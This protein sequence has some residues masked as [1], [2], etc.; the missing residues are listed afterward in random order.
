VRVVTLT[1]EQAVLEL[2]RNP[3]YADLVRDAYLGPDVEG[4]A[5]RFLASEEF[6][7]VLRL[8]GDRARGGS[9]LDVG[10]GTGVAS[11]AFARSG[12]R[13]VVAL[14]PDSGDVVGQG[15]I[16]RISNGLPITI[17]TG[18]G[19]ALPFPDARFDVVYARQV[20]HHASDLDAL[21]RECARVVVPG[22][23]VLATREHVVDDEAQLRAFLASHPVHQ[24]AG[25]ENAHSLEAYR[26]AFRRA[27]LVR[28]RVLG[29]YDSVINAFPAFQDE[30]SLAE[31]PRRVL[32][33]WFGTV[34]RLVARVPGVQGV[35]RRW[36]DE[37][38]PGRLYSFVG[39]K[40]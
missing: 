14:E 19:E 35:V 3:R 20:L 18:V 9:V 32:E 31:Y 6:A 33:G 37:P 22:G 26:A 17:A 30:R 34:G 38:V 28:L 10:A 27:G 13:E 40:L 21:V 12:A 25:G 11:Y 1:T 23:I 16:R 24:L 5:A 7:A 36:I 4:N 8:L 2:R 15:A 29:P 39:R